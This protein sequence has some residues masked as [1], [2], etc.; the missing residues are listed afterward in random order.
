LGLYW[1][2]DLL[3]SGWRQ[4]NSLGQRASLALVGLVWLPLL[5]IDFTRAGHFRRWLGLPAHLAAPIHLLKHL[6]GVPVHL[7]IRGPQYPESWL[8]RAPVLDIFVLSASLI[9]I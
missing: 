9:G 7:F 1:H 5:T 3:A 6:I 4:F 8:G 2:R